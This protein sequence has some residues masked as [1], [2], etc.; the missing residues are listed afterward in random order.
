MEAAIHFLKSA[1][2]ALPFELIIVI[3][4]IVALFLVCRY[5]LNEMRRK[6]DKIE[7]MTGVLI[8]SSNVL[9]KVID[10]I[11]KIRN[12]QEKILERNTQALVQEIKLAASEVKNEIKDLFIKHNK[13]E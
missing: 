5:F 11:E 10:N 2:G 12:E 6:D 4:L 9:S 7:K 1:W 3:G 8:E 13:G